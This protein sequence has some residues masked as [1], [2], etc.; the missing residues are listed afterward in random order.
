MA[1]PAR[2]DDAEI[3]L[4]SIVSVRIVL[5][6]TK[7]VVASYLFGSAKTGTSASRECSTS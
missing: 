4:G 5:Y 7:C 2:A 1:A 3:K 6:P